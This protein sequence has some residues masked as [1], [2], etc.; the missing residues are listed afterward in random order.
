MKKISLLLLICLLCSAVAACSQDDSKYKEMIS[1]ANESFDHHMS[2][3]QG[4]LSIPSGLSMPEGSLVKPPMDDFNRVEDIGTPG[5]DYSVEVMELYLPI[6]GTGTP[7]GWYSKDG[8]T[9]RLYSYD[10]EVLWEKKIGRFLDASTFGAVAT[11]SSG[12]LFVLDKS[13]N[14]LW[15]GENQPDSTGSTLAAIAPDGYVYAA[16]RSSNG[17]ILRKYAPDGTLTA[18][19]EYTTAE[20]ADVYAMKYVE[21]YGLVLSMSCRWMEDAEKDFGILLLNDDLSTKWLCYADTIYYENLTAKDGFLYAGSYN[22][23]ICISLGDGSIAATAKG[24][25]ISVGSMIYLQERQTA[26]T[27]Y[28]RELKTFSELSIAGQTA[29][30]VEEMED[31]GLLVMTKNLLGI[32]PT[33][34]EVSSIWYEYEYVYTRY[35][36]DGEIL[37]RATYDNNQK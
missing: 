27:V 4:G 18:Q 25:L 37:Y 2:L 35:D 33:P 15:D 30:R 5:T 12:K 26:L 16:V 23:T 19:K 20:N 13:G 11:D 22:K 17:L 32:A 29:L 34:P 24:K 10:G 6:L 14:T 36:K 9:L 1:R 7:D 28:D 8:S 21:G 31:G 3:Q